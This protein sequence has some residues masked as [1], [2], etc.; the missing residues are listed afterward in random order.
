MS[1]LVLILK[2][3]AFQ[4]FCRR[5]KEYSKCGRHQ[6]ASGPLLEILGY[7]ML[8]FHMFISVCYLQVSNVH[9]MACKKSLH[10]ISHLLRGAIVSA[11][12]KCLHRISRL[13]RGESVRGDRKFVPEINHLLREALVTTCRKCLHGISCLLRGEPVR[14]DRKCMPE[15]NHLLMEARVTKGRKGVQEINHLLRGGPVSFVLSCR[16]CWLIG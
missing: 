6:M 10:G 11:C 3:G 16:V 8:Q 15:I 5:P 14:G 9:Q 12:R 7:R 13:L 2:F 1:Q 4:I